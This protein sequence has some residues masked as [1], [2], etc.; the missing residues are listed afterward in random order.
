MRG[1]PMPHALILT[2][3]SIVVAVLAGPAC[4]L[5]R[6]RPA[7]VPPGVASDT[8][9]AEL[10]PSNAVEPVFHVYERSQFKVFAAYKYTIVAPDG[11]RSQLF[12]VRIQELDAEGQALRGWGMTGADVKA[13]FDGGM[14]QGKQPVGDGTFRYSLQAWGTAMDRR[15][16]AVIA[17]ATSGQ[18]LTTVP[19]NGFWYL[20]IEGVTELD[21]WTSI[22]V[23]D[24][25]GNVLH[26]YHT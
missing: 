5:N 26:D 11:L 21:R 13:D 9:L 10:L 8:V 2:L 18:T 24:V 3:V 14:S 15:A 20:E 12:G 4:N 6:I 25:K 19:R 23:V 17:Q 7:A 1:K 22:R 16:V